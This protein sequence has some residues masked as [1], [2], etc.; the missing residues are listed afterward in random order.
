MSVNFFNPQRSYEGLGALEDDVAAL[1]D[2]FDV[3]F[4]STVEFF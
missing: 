2:G 3:M 1:V 4:A